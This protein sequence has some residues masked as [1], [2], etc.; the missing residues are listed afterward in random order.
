MCVYTI[1]RDRDREV[2]NLSSLGK[3]RNWERGKRIKGG[4]EEGVTERDWGL[5]FPSIHPV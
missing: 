4:E 5:A 1:D 2:E 3:E